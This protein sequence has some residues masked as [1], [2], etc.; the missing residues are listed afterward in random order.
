MEPHNKKAPAY[1]EA[2]DYIDRY[3]N[4]QGSPP[5]ARGM[6]AHFGNIGSL[7]TYVNYIKRWKNEAK[8]VSVPGGEFDHLQKAINDFS[9]MVELA[10]RQRERLDNSKVIYLELENYALR[11]RIAELESNSENERDA[12][13][14]ASETVQ[15]AIDSPAPDPGVKPTRKRRK[16]NADGDGASTLVPEPVEKA[17][18]GGD[19]VQHAPSPI[20]P[21]KSRPDPDLLEFAAKNASMKSAKS[22]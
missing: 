10:E 13:A 3:E 7:E 6:Q 20:T 1:D 21:R 4:K 19:A 18:M 2:S 8:N 12:D 15:K 22:D 11:E 14:S 9:K 16:R 5:T 17:N